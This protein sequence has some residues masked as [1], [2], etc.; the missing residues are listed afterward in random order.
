MAWK[1]MKLSALGAVIFGALKPSS[2]SAESDALIAQWASR[3]LLNM[4]TRNAFLGKANSLKI[5]LRLSTMEFQS[6]RE[7]GPAGTP[8]A[9]IRSISKSPSLLIR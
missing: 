1:R 6:C 9:A 8:I 2:L 4:E 7:L 3:L 5:S